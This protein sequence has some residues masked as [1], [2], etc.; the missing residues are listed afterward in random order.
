[1]HD[2]SRIIGEMEHALTTNNFLRL[3]ALEG[4]HKN[5]NGDPFKILIGTI[6]SSRTRDENTTKALIKLFT[7]YKGANDISKANPNDIKKEIS[8]VGFYNIKAIR[9]KEVAEIIENKFHG[10]VP[11][12]EEELLKLPGVGRKTA[13]CVLVYAF[14]K[15]AIPVDTH[16]H[17]ISNRLNLVNTKTPKD[18]EKELNEY[19]D[20]K[21]WIR[22]NSTFVRYGQNICLPLRPKCSYCNL[23]KICRYYAKNERKKRRIVS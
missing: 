12:S 13:N 17:R 16:V 10:Q 23:R 2:L 22:L 15:S 4:L 14:Q 9:I 18:T 11:D 7:R 20:K 3:T 8:S 6:L 1:M 21:L 5:E 19:V